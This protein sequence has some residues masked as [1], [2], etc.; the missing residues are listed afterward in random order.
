MYNGKARPIIQT[1][2]ANQIPTKFPTKLSITKTNGKNT[3][4]LEPINTFLNNSVLPNPLKIPS[5]EKAIA[6]MGCV[7]II[8]QNEALKTSTTK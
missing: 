5:N 1:L 7:R 2:N 3:N 8:T 4:K 6:L